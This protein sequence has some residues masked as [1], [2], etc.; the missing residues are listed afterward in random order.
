MTRNWFVAPALALAVGFALFTPSRTAAA[1]PAPQ[2]GQQPG[3]DTPPQEY[4]DVQR[5]GFHDGIAGA[6]RDHGN[7]RRPDVNNREEYRNA[8]DMPHDIPPNMRDA[9]RDAFRRGYEMAASRLWGMPS[10]PPPPPQERQNWDDWGM[11]GLR[12]DAERQ[13]YREG[14]EEGRKDFQFRR[15]ADP[16]DHQEFRNPPVAPALADE[17]REGFTRGYTVANSQ[18]NGEPSWQQYNGDPDRWQTPNAWSETERRGF[19]DGIQGAR[20]DYGNNRRPNVNN[21]EEYRSP[22]L[23]PQLRGE[24]RQGFRR[25]YE[26]TAAHLWGG[27]G[28]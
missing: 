25:G 14:V 16:D 4:N 10:P 17:Y 3:W 6:N 12:S 9:Y 15:P 27:A 5:R 2:Y 13:G 19:H 8:D 26:I 24:Y 22:D 21:R 28:M 11:R 23:P 1:A 20:K 7:G 18:L